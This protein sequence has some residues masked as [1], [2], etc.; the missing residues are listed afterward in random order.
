MPRPGRLIKAVMG[1]F[2]GLG[3]AF[4]ANGWPDAGQGRHDNRCWW[5]GYGRL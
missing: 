4:D 2:P 1:Y 3:P 5:S